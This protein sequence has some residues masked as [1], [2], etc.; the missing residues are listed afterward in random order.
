MPD[1]PNQVFHRGAIRPLYD[2]VHPFSDQEEADKHRAT[3]ELAQKAMEE[4]AERREQEAREKAQAKSARD[5]AILQAFGRSRFTGSDEEFEE[6]WPQLR[7]EINKH[8][9]AGS[10]SFS[11]IKREVIGRTLDHLSL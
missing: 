5:E 8:L 7:K 10:L 11:A 1:R 2:Q 3:R 9:A 4:A 6:A